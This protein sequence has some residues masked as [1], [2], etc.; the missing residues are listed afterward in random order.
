[1]RCEGY[2]RNSVKQDTHTE[3]EIKRRGWERDNRV[4]NRVIRF[5]LPQVNDSGVVRI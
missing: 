4:G 5:S 3:M 2:L 1:M